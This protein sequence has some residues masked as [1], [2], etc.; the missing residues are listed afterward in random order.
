MTNY[1]FPGTLG[2]LSKNVCQCVVSDRSTLV[3]PE[4]LSVVS[5]R[6]AISA[7]KVPKY[8][9]ERSP[10][11]FC[12]PELQSVVSDRLAGSSFIQ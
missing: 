7:C 3:R 10:F 12:Q 5:D 4:F 2:R 6:L 11:S 8:C 1:Q 9:V